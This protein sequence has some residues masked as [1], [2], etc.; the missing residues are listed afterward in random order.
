MNREKLLKNMTDQVKE[1]RLKLGYA[2]ETVR[3]YY[4]VDSLNTILGSNAKDDQEMLTLLRKAFEAKSSLGELH[5]YSHAGR[6]EISIPPEG[7]QW[8]HEQV[9]T[10]AFLKDLIQLFQEHH[11]CTLEEIC[12]VFENHGHEYVCEKMPEGSDFDYAIHFKDPS[13]DEYYYCIHME[14]GHTI[15]HRFTESDYQAML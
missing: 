8:V 10:P 5:F 1:A 6:V 4:P 11:A 15:Y 7:S 12:Q 2:K 3:L 14:M 9:E 13:I